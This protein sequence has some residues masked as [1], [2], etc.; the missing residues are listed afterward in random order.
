MKQIGGY[1]FNIHTI[2]YTN[3]LGKKINVPMMENLTVNRVNLT[4]FIMSI[5]KGRTID[6]NKVWF[7][8]ILENKFGTHEVNKEEYSTYIR[9]NNKELYGTY[10]DKD[11]FLAYIQHV[12]PKFNIKAIKFTDNTLV[13]ASVILNYVKEFYNTNEIKELRNCNYRNGIEDEIFD[14]FHDLNEIYTPHIFYNNLNK[15][16]IIDLTNEE[17]ELEDLKEFIMTVKETKNK[18]HCIVTKKIEWLHEN[19]ITMTKT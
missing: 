4:R 3:E 12:V 5:G 1:S 16:I 15:I 11:I 2:E 13:E 6:C 9:S 18:V 14:S 17:L 7:Q 19:K 10:I 8:K